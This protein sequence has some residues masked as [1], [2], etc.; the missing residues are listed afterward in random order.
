MEVP[1]ENGMRDDDI[2]YSPLAAV[3]LS[4]EEVSICAEIT[5]NYFVIGSITGKQRTVPKTFMDPYITNF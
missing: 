5:L 1:Y 3:S 2:P 4:A